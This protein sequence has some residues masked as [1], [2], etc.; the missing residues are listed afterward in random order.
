VTDFLHVFI[1]LFVAMDLFGLIPIFIGLTDGMTEDQRRRVAY[2][3]VLTALVISIFFLAVGTWI[4]KVLG[5]SLSDFQI[6]GGLLLL[7]F[8]VIEI[9]NHSPRDSGPRLKVGPVPLG[10]P[11][12]VGPA[13]LTSLLLLT[14]AYGYPLTL[15]ALCL[16]LILVTLALTFTK[17]VKRIMGENGL[18]AISQV[19]HLFLA[20]IGVSLIRHGLR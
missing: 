18:Q 15:T 8:A 12:I 10:T 9:L 11:L 19:I 17:H 6:A 2:T 16:N 20:A 13:V 3:G 5:I 4:F 7:V 14:P 1:P